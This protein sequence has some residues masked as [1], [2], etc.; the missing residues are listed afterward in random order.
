M[1]RRQALKTLAYASTII[2]SAAAAYDEK[3][4]TNTKDIAVKDMNNLTDFEA[5]HLPLITVK[6]KDKAGYTLVEVTV[7]HKDI[8]HP[9]TDNHWIYAIE[10]FADDKPVANVKLEPSISRGFLGARV[11]LDNVKTLKA[12]ARCNLHGN[13]TYELAL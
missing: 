13:F 4:I 8:I 10:L 3:L 11:K 6:D 9:S 1:K 12:I 2:A 7:G 5:K